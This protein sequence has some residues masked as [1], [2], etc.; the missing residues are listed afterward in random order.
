MFQNLHKNDCQ[1]ARDE[2]PDAGKRIK[3]KKRS[4]YQDWH[5]RDIFAKNTKWNSVVDLNEIY[6]FVVIL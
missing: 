5:A 6:T 4:S 2:G 3:I 1:T